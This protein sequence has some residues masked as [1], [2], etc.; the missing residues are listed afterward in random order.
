MLNKTIREMLLEFHYVFGHPI[1]H[2]P[3]LVPIET[4]RLRHNM[5]IEEVN[6]Y[7]K[8]CEE[9]NLEAIADA[10]GDIEYVLAGTAVAHGM[11]VYP[12]VKEIHESNMTKLGEDGKPIYREDGKVMKG[13]NYVPPDMGK[14]L[15]NQ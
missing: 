14:A 2:H 7:L 15:R 6:E 3:T 5:L 12:L 11:K 10:I 8:A 1:N 13:P 9:G 4:A